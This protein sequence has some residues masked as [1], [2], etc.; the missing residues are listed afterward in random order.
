MPSSRKLPQATDKAL[1]NTVFV[2]DGFTRFSAEGGGVGTLLNDK[3]HQIVIGTYAS[4]K[5]YRA[6]FV[7]GNVYQAS[8]DFSEN[9][10]SDL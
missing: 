3:C 2:I 5:A 4:Q 10:G 8:V 9:F 6:N 7:Y 1:S